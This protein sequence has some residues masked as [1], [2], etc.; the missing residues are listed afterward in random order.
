MFFKIIKYNKNIQNKLDINKNDYKKYC[1]I[2][3]E[4]M[5]TEDYYYSKEPFINFNNKEEGSYYHIYYNDKK[6]ETK[7][8]KRNYITRNIKKIK[9]IIDYLIKSFEKLFQNCGCIKSINFIKFN[10]NDINNMSS[11]FNRCH[12][13]IELNL[14]NFNSY[15]VTNMSS[16]F[17]GCSL[18]KE[19]N[20]SNLILIMLIL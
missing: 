18:L 3:I 16:M 9:I 10:R 15:N 17:N 19:L 8:K 4:I 12:S 1:E 7:R 2:E 14:S 13:L 5:P 20:L 6:E 11:M